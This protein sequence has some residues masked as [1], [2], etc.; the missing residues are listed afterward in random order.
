MR[1]FL[2]WF[3]ILAVLAGGATALAFS[4]RSWW[5]MRTAPKFLTAEVSRGRV[6]TVVN[7]TG[8]VKPVRT[9]SVGAFTSGPILEVYVD[10]NSEIT[11]K[12]QVLAL[13]DPKL[14]LAAVKRDKA[15]V[16]TQEAEVER[17]EAL[18]DQAKRN[19]KRATDLNDK[20]PDYIS[21]TD[22]EQFGY[23]VITYTKQ[24]KLAK[25]NVDQA[26]ATLQNSEEQL[27]YTKVLGPKEIDPEKGV[28]GKVIERKVDP[29]QTVVASF[30]TPELF[31]VGLE[32]DTHMH[33]YASV[34]EADVGQIEAARKT[35]RRATFT[36]DAYPGEL[37]EGTILDVRLNTTTTQ[38]VVTYPVIIDAPNPDKK[39]KPNMTA[40]ITF[41]IEAKEDVLRV[42]VAALRFVPQGPQ[43]RPEDRHYIDALPTNPSEGAPKR[44]A[45][46]KADLARKRQHRI[47]WVQDGSLL[48]AVPVTLGLTD[49]QYA[50]LL[51]GDLKDGQ[52]VVTGVESQ[53]AR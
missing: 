16:E 14:Q 33:V 32:M 1:R 6:E 28:R 47:V 27:N 20:N 15:A 11:E 29:G 25:A 19:L 41:P 40:N 36:V 46:E 5:Q 13:I 18:L 35:K 45:E 52:A 8:N 3:V 9:V 51:G 24:I 44:S 10:Y 2:W 22:L 21:K 26:R 17:L 12:N 31:I 49:N 39:L 42:P 34:D 30:Q 53:F 43:V 38:N 7:S 48:R 37:F 23:T 4:A 50:E